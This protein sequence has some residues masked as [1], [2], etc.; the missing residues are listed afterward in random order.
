MY[1]QYSHQKLYAHFVSVHDNSEKC[2]S[3]QKE[4]AKMLFYANIVSLKPMKTIGHQMR[5]VS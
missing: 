2:L 5:L 3:V 1:N 4:H